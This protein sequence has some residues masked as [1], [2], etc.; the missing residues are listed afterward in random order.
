METSATSGEAGDDL[1]HELVDPLNQELLK[2][3]QFGVSTVE[4]LLPKQQSGAAAG[5]FR[6]SILLVSK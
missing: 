1:Q 6:S 3:N 2:P 4:S 5:L